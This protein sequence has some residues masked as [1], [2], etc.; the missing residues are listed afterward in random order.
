[1]KTPPR[2]LT[3]ITTRLANGW[4]YDIAESPS[5]DD[6]RWPFRAALGAPS[7]TAASQSLGEVTKWSLDW[8]EWASERDVHLA[9]QIRSIGGVKRSMPT[10]L[11]VPDVDTA[12]RLAG[13]E[14][15]QR[16][17]RG[18][19]RRA[20]VLE[21]FPTAPAA[22]AI[23]LADAMSDTD[24][25]LALDA[26]AWFET[27]PEDQW[28]A[29]TPRQVPIPGLHAKW[30]DSNRQLVQAL[31]G[32]DDLTLIQRPTRVYWTYL[33][34]AYRRTGSRV[35]DSL[36]LGDTVT[37]P[38]Q[39]TIVLIVENKDSAV[40]F[41]ELAGGIVVE[42]NGQASVGLL[43]QVSWIKDAK[44]LIYWGDI[45]QR[46]Y[47]IVDGLRHRLRQL[48]TILMDRQ[49]YDTYARFGTEFE[50]NGNP[51]KLRPRRAL[52]Y[53]IPS[54]REMY[55]ALSDPDWP[56]HRRFEQE[57]VPLPTARAAVHRLVGMQH[58][59]QPD[60]HRRAPTP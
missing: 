40:L 2:V 57:R 39:P 50:P 48:R 43:P 22:A 4:H 17:K 41:P 30:L 55:D 44:T 59:E 35:H 51:I 36:T 19:T 8:R 29:L 24:F 53:L 42:G 38:Y 32:L 46:G 31:G 45:D 33:D 10:H 37:L 26:A 20:L 14:W 34:P 47:E 6:G 7:S 54:E 25:A 12:A 49:T 52:V 9:D 1:M 23:R 11:I 28:R 56:S 18:R 60:L 27:T 15:V 5:D 13:P 3:E 21:R 58:H 16:V